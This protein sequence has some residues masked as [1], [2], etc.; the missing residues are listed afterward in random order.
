MFGKEAFI[1]GLK[2]LG[3]AAESL[4]GNRIAFQYTIKGGRFKDQPIKVG[5]EVP[6]DF[7]EPERGRERSRR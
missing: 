4:D 6:A 2:E 1:Q 7:N 3:Y 5:I